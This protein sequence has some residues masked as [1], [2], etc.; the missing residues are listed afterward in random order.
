MS[1]LIWM[2]AVG[3]IITAGATAEFFGRFT[4]SREDV[5][6]SILADA[7]I[8]AAW[9]LFWAFAALILTIGWIVDV[10]KRQER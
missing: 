9:P 8:G 5:T 4:Q 2:A 1:F 6:D 7:V 10:L 3:Y